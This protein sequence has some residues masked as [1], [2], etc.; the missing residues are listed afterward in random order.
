L[1]RGLHIVAVIVSYKKLGDF[2]KEG[3]TETGYAVSNNVKVIF[4]YVNMHL[5]VVIN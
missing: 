3:H 1:T 4:A 5:V 2:W